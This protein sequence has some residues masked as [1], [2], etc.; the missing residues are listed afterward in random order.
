MPSCP[1]VHLIPRSKGQ[2]GAKIRSPKNEGI[3]GRPD[4]IPP[5][6][7]KSRTKAAIARAFVFTP[8]STK[9]ARLSSPAPGVG[10]GAELTLK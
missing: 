4:A 1:F 8:A 6:A 10:P 9:K 2:K 7:R 3:I 5:R